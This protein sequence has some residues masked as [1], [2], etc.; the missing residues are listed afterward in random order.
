ME[1]AGEA[2]FSVINRKYGVS[3]K[4]FTVVCGGGNNGG[5]GFVL[6]RKLHAGG[7]GVKIIL[8][9]SRDKFKGAAK[10]NL[11]IS[12]RINVDFI[13]AAN[14]KQIETALAGADIV[15]DAI[16]GTGLDRNAESIFKAAIEAV[17]ESGKAVIALDIP[18]GINGDSGRE[19]GASIRANCTVTF[20]LPKYGNLLYPGY[21]RCGELYHAPISFPAELIKSANLQS[22]IS[23]PDPLPARAADTS[24]MEYGPVLVIAGAASY[25]WAPHASAYSFLKSGGGYVFL[26]CPRSIA[27]IV[28]RKGREIVFRL[29]DET[30]SGSIA[31]S[32]KA[33]LLKLASR[34]KMV[35]LGPGI[36]L[37]EEIQQLARELAAEIETPLLIDADGITAVSKAPAILSNRKGPTILTPHLGEMSRLSG[38]ST[39]D[40]ENNRVAA[41]RETAHRLN[42]VIIL[43][44]PHTLIGYP[45]GQ[46]FINPSGTTGGK[47]GMATAGAGDVLNGTIAAMYCLGQDLNTAVRT[48]VFIHGL[49]GDIAASKK[50]ADG[51]TAQ[52][53][54]NNLPY[55]V[56]EFRKDREKL[57]TNIY[58]TVFEL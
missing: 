50:G 11:E 48:G 12:S 7:A 58:H 53:I 25:Y 33:E 8:I 10:Q 56:K 27:P 2:A 29:Q 40:I 45:D 31:L 15:V 18:S 21:A 52:D 36:S 49:S 39:G 35:I 47:A 54:L 26:A 28:A 3:G 30:E 42:A 24:K 34:V 13:E 17:N 51:M 32:N 44:G 5:D 19:M 43:K 14:R 23:I 41:V 38:Q 16:F 6:A 22:N 1:S 46:I 57:V 4:N 37:D 55:A 20:G 9:A